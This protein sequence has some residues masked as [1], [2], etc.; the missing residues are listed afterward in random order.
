MRI[1]VLFPEICNLYGDLGNIEYLYKSLDCEIVET[2][3]H[4]NP[5]FIDGG[6][7]L[8][9]MGST[10]EQGQSLAYQS[11]L[12]YKGAIKQRITEGGVCLFTGNAVDLLGDYILNEDGSQEK[13]LGLYSFHTKRE[14][15]NRHNS[16]YLGKYEDIE[17]VG[18]KSLFGLAYEYQ[19]EHL[20]ETVRG[21]GMNQIGEAEGIRDN[22]LFAT[23]LMG[24][25]LVMNPLFTHKL[26][27][28]LNC[29][30][31][32]AHEE[33][34]MAAYKQRLVEF[35]DTKRNFLYH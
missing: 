19:G 35:H 15:F 26:L 18:F 30:G 6:I 13:M 25:L 7:D 34:A 3:L 22:N 21:V 17:I 20:F 27:N 31:P 16:F 11:L 32:L 24:P 1:E 12:P 10:T 14:M 4:I 8:L 33:V 23:Y 28:I 9:Y 29:D 2:G 5:K